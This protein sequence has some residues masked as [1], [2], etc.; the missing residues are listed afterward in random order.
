MLLH[1]ADTRIREEEQ[2]SFTFIQLL[3]ENYLFCAT[4]VP[5]FLRIR[6]YS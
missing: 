5:S 1:K 4:N 3:A 6:P 2:G